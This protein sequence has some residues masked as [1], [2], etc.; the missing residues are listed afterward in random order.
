MASTTALAWAGA[1]GP[2]GRRNSTLF[3]VIGKYPSPLPRLT[4]DQDPGQGEILSPR[5]QGLPRFLHVE[6]G[7]TKVSKQGMHPSRHSQVGAFR[8]L[9]QGGPDEHRTATHHGR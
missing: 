5:R 6:G 2:A 1:L 8:L 4:C 7:K 9:G 3:M